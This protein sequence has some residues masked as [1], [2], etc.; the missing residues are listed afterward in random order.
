MEFQIL[1]H[2]GLAVTG[3]GKQLICDP[4]LIGSTY[5]RSWWNYPPVSPELVA[6]LKPDFI[7]LTHVHWD[8]FQGPS[9]R[10]F[11]KSTII[12]IPREPRGRMKADLHQMGYRNTVE[13]GHGQSM[14]LAPGFTVTSYHF[15]IFLDSA[16]V[17]EGDGKVLLNAND[18][19]FMGGPLRQILRNHPKIDFVFRSHS[20]ANSRLCYEILDNPSHS[21]DD[22]NTRYIRDFANFVAMTGATYAIPLASN[23]CF[24]HKDVYGLNHT[25]NTPDQVSRYFETH[26]VKGPKVQV[27]VSGDQWSSETGF[28]VSEKS[29]F[30]DRDIHLEEYRR[31]KEPV[32]EKFYAQEARATLNVKAV[33]KFFAKFLATVPWIVRLFFKG[34]PTHYILTAGEK[35]WIFQV[36]VHRGTVRELETLDP[37]AMPI[38]IETSAYIFKQCMALGLFS[39]LGI[40]KRVRFRSKAADLKYLWALGFLFNMHEYQMLPLRRMLAPRFIRGWIPRWREVLLYGNL[41]RDKALG[42]RLIMDRYLKP[43]PT[44]S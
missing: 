22:D 16:L 8:H 11:P 23:H 32:I 4:W 5:W 36:D 42:R 1:S 44:E 35:R 31:E 37:A 41:V 21:L 26:R 28:H 29:W 18:A 40:S 14:E 30:R 38:Q 12:I 34:K 20:S 3:A 39:S 9:L 25:V 19:K 6:S 10:K 13:L 33:E 27:M 7:Y 15:S 43:A 24:L 2:A 17:I